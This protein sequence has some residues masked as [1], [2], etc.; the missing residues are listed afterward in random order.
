MDANDRLMLA[1]NSV[2]STNKKL[3]EVLQHKDEF[4]LALEAFRQSLD[5]NTSFEV[6]SI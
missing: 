1:N 2:S 6:G 3:N 5:R 4:L